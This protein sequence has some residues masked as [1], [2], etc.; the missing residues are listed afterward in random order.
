MNLHK[1]KNRYEKNKICLLIASLFVVSA[2]SANHKVTGSIKDIA[3][4]SIPAA[5]IQYWLQTPLLSK[6]A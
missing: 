6:E 2:Y 3:Q 1:I 4:N 5:T